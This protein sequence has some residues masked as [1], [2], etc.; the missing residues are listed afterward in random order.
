MNSLIVTMLDYNMTKK[1]K[2]V[3]AL[4]ATREAIWLRCIKM[5]MKLAI[6]SLVIVCQLL[7]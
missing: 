4:S 6:Q 5:G 2:Y 1:A 3:S 7:Q